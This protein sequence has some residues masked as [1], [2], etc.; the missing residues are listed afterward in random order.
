MAETRVVC[1]KQGI[2]TYFTNNPF[3]QLRNEKFFQNVWF[4]WK[5]ISQPFN[6]LQILF[7]DK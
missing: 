2:E 6:S 1:E 7:A 5:A 4:T 3:T